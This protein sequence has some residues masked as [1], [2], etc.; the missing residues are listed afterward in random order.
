MGVGMCLCSR[1]VDITRWVLR[2]RDSND[3]EIIADGDCIPVV[4][5]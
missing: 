5:V 1:D 4:G 3:D 2:C